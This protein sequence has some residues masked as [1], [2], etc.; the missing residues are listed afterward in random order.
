MINCTFTTI[1]ETKY[2]SQ[3]F[4]DKTIDGNMALSQILFSELHKIMR[5][6]LPIWVL[7][8]AIAQKA[9]PCGLGQF[10]ATVSAMVVANVLC[11]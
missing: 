9:L 6:K 11:E 7:G 5:I 1:R 4:C 8:E 10:G 3:D 2:T